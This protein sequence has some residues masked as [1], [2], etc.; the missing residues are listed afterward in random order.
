MPGQGCRNLA[1]FALLLLIAGCAGEPR[2]TTPLAPKAAE[3]LAT[4]RVDPAAAAR[5]LN[6]YRRGRG[7]SPVTLDP[8]LSAMAQ[9]QA[10]AMVASNT[11]SHDTGGSFGA[12][13]HAAGLDA[14]RAAE[15]LGAGY[16]STEEAFAGWKTSSGH[17]AN[18]RMAEA[19]R[20]GIALAKDPGT[21]YGAWW[22][23]VIAGEP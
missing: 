6:D 20:F 18:L 2:R 15:N 23:F 8:A 5:I 9:R 19:T 1:A 7:L 11:L 16:Y 17:D 21:R 14:S 22:A 3:R 13:V 12:R 10:D 4:V